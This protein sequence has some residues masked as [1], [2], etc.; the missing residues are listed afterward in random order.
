MANH[1]QNFVSEKYIH[2]YCN[3]ITNEILIYV[4]PWVDEKEIYVHVCGNTLTAAQQ[5]E[6]KE[7]RCLLACVQ[8]LQVLLWVLFPSLQSDEL[9]L[10]V[11]QEDVMFVLWAVCWVFILESCSIF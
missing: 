3:W 9:Q 1:R 5:T 6:R 11:I 2:K 4:W 7:Y 8:L 10:Q